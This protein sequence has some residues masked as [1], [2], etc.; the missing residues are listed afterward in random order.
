[1]FDLLNK[2]QGIVFGIWI[3]IAFP[4]ILRLAFTLAAQG[5]QEW[6]QLFRRIHPDSKS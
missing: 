5:W 3:I 6:K 2:L 1:V 4:A